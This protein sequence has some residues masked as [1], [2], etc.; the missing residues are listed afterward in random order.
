M[1]DGLFFSKKDKKMSKNKIKTALPY[2][3]EVSKTEPEIFIIESLHVDD[4]IKERYEG[5]ALRDALR[6]TGQKPAYYYVRTKEELANAIEL[7]LH[8]GY[9]F[10]HISIHGSKTGVDTTLE[11]MTNKEFANLFQGKLKN[12][13]IFFSACEVGSGG[14]SLLLQA[15]NPGMYS[16][17]SPLDKILFGTACAF[18]IAFYTRVLSNNPLGMEVSELTPALTQLCQFFSVR[19]EWSYYCPAPKVKAWKT[20]QIP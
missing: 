8:S 19:L 7:F 16:V 4:E 3:K 17:A 9:R 20:I 6:V 1:I 10:L 18:W 14:L 13:R 15:Q 5:R 2:R 11:R 12:R